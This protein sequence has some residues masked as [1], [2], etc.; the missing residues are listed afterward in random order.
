MHEMLFFHILSWIHTEN[1]A[2]QK[3]K[4]MEYVM[5]SP[6]GIITSREQ[7]LLYSM[8]TNHWQDIS[9]ERM[10]QQSKQLGIRT[11]DI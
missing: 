8:T 5:Q 7:K 11:S 6:N 9:M 3:K 10:Q 4:F 1:V 2:P